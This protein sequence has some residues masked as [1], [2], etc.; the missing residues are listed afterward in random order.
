MNEFT[1]LLILDLN[2]IIWTQIL[3]NFNLSLGPI[4]VN[5]TALVEFFKLIAPLELIS[6]FNFISFSGP[7]NSTSDSDKRPPLF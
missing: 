7:S 5:L 1:L 4:S 6:C 3:I 2:Q